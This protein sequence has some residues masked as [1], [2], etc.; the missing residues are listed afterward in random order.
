VYVLPTADNAARVML[1]LRRFGA[2]VAAHGIS[3]SD[4]SNLGVV[5]QIGLPPNRI[6]LLTS[7]SGVTFEECLVDSIQ[8]RLGTQQVRFL[9]IEAQ[10]KNKR[11]TGRTKDLADAEVLEALIRRASE[12]SAG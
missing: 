10:L 1:A 11:A 7:L 3:V 8:G 4:F 5:Y 2:P 6:D 12:L 9:G